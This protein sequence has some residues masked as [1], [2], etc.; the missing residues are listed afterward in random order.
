LQSYESSAATGKAPVKGPEVANPNAWPVEGLESD[1]IR[2]DREEVRVAREKTAAMLRF[3]WD[4]RQFV[5]RL[6]GAGLALSTMIA[7]LIP[8]QFESTTHLMPPDQMNSGMAMLAAAAG[9]QAASGLG[10]VAGNLLGLKSTG[11]L[12]IAI[13]QSRTVENDLVDKLDLRRV[14]AVRQLG[15]ARSALDDHTSISE[16]RKSGIITIQV[17]DNNPQR[18]AAIGQE[19]VEELNRV[20]TELNTSSAHRER[21]FLEERLAQVK[22]DLETAEKRFSEYASK[23]TAIDIQAQGKAM[24]EAAAALEGQLI[25]ARTELESMKQVYT[26]D[27][28]RVRATQARVDELQ[29]ELQRLG[30]KYDV[31]TVATPEND[32]SMYPSIRELPLL[33]VNYAD[34]YRTTKVQDMT[35]VEDVAR[36]NILAATADV[37]S[38]FFNVGTGTATSVTQVFEYLKELLGYDLDPAL[39]KQDINLV[40][41]RQCST[42][43][44]ERILGF[45]SHVTVPEGLSNYVLWRE[46]I[47]GG[48]RHGVGIGAH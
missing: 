28:V 33:G 5:L 32:K 6:A 45:K 37:T 36:A 23:N 16:D 40:K 21:L 18:A 47:A 46:Q 8:K 42:E 34:L 41:R 25:A 4:R 15:D 17:T 2:A 1:P 7:F 13:L 43:K 3:V 14:Y 44:A 26:G 27:N 22:Q 35:Y 31:G 29:R 19:Y 10:A 30:G 9:T 24:I 11:A 20:V 38:D 12:F 39:V 48:V